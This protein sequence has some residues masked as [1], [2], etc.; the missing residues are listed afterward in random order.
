MSK[1][2]SFM[3][4]REI[5]VTVGEKFYHILPVFEAGPDLIKSSQNTASSSSH[6][7]KVIDKIL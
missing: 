6:G 3:C 4:I 2:N 1:D 7:A 5:P